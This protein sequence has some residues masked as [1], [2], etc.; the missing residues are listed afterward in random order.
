MYMLKWYKFHH[1]LNLIRPPAVCFRQAPLPGVPGSPGLP[2]SACHIL[3]IS[4]LSFS[5][6]TTSRR[7]TVLLWRIFDTVISKH[8]S[9]V[10]LRVARFKIL[11][12][13]VE[14]KFYVSIQRVSEQFPN[15][16]II[17]SFRRTCRRTGSCKLPATVSDQVHV[18]L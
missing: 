14:I 17:N 1:G 18:D 8:V 16:S 6:L 15:Y 4:L 7:W 2:G 10:V 9:R 13:I 3:Y 11:Y 5:A 12:P